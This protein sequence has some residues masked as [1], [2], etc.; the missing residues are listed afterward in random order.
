M[1]GIVD[2]CKQSDCVLLGGEVNS[3][4]L[5]GDRETFGERIS[6]IN[7][8]LPANISGAAVRVVHGALGAAQ[9][10]AAVGATSISNG[11]A[12]GTASEYV[13][14]AAGVDIPVIVRRAADG[15]ALY[16][17]TVSLEQGKAY[18]IFVSG[19]TTLLSHGEMLTDN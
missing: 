17:A 8:G 14:V 12:I 3:I 15:Q 1:K 16:R 13:E 6:V 9:I 19:N 11:T 5:F 10:S 4:I 2:G 18:S 7:D